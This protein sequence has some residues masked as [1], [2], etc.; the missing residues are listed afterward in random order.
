MNYT[1]INFPIKNNPP[2]TDAKSVKDMMDGLE[3]LVKIG[4]IRGPID[5]VLVDYKICKDEGYTSAK[6]KPGSMV[7]ASKLNTVGAYSTFEF[8]G[9]MYEEYD[10][11][12]KD[13]SKTF[14]VATI[15][16]R[17]KMASL[18]PKMRMKKIVMDYKMFYAK[19]KDKLEKDKTMAKN[20]RSL[21]LSDMMAQF[22]NVVPLIMEGQQLA[23]LLGLSMIDPKLNEY[24]RVLSITYK[25]AM[26][27]EQK[28]G[29]LN[30]GVY[31]PVKKAYTEFMDQLTLSVFPGIDSIIGD[32]STPDVKI[33][34]KVSEK[35]AP[36]KFSDT[37]YKYDSDGRILLFS[38]EDDDSDVTPFVV[39]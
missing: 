1:L 5:D 26:G 27:Q 4:A 21:F 3:I 8:P 2:L 7:D 38:D 19:S 30:K 18:D 14:S 29:S 11:F 24:A 37:R 36:A 22:N 31:G 13:S 33:V 17:L 39:L 25:R 34:G 20:L 12:V 16:D 28:S 10:S 35:E 6:L 23:P 15:Q 9:D 32:E